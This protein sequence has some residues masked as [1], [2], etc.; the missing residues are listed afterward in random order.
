ML[1]SRE[2][3]RSVFSAMRPCFCSPNALLHRHNC[4]IHRFWKAVLKTTDPGCPL[5]PALIE[6]NFTRI[7]RRALGRL[8]VVDAHRYS[9]HCFRRGAANA[10]RKSGSTLSEITQ[11]GDGSHQASRCISTYTAPRKL[12]RNGY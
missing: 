3:S 12:V 1:A 6:K 9:P 10:I 8:G 2:N 4:P 11:T 5:F 7:P